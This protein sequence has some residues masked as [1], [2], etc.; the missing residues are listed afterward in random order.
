MRMA[1]QHCAR[2][3][4]SLMARLFGFIGNHKELGARVLQALPEPVR[5]HSS[6]GTA[7][8]WGV[9]FFQNGEG[10][11]RRR[12]LDER[13][14][15]DVGKSVESVATDVLVGHIRHP[16]VGNLRTENTHPFR[17]RDW[18]FA[19]IGTV[20]GFD[21]LRD[22]LFEA[23]PG[24]LR[25]NVRGDTDSEVFFYLILSFL[26]DAGVLENRS[27]SR[28][29][30]LDALAAASKHVDDKLV[31]AGKPKHSGDILMTNGEH[32][33]AVQRSGRLAFRLVDDPEDAEALL[34]I[35][36]NKPPSSRGQ[37]R[38]CVFASEVQELPE[39][40][41]HP[42]M[43]HVLVASRTEGPEECELWT[44]SSIS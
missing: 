26:H 41:Q 4:Q 25:P 16:T 7:H 12:P 9:A 43:D 6:P 30:V 36:D 11:L 3:S 13:D 5:V 33:Y 38:S 40:W 39:G 35:K 14:A 37:Q 18:V 28:K 22:S 1:E 17:Y 10:L 2:Y 29:Y 24:F 21:G 32:M 27:V 23:Q 42:A 20:T 8:G 34:D 19:Q 44:S 15:I 31:A